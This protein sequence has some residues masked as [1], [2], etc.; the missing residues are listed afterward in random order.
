MNSP[1]FRTK[2]R[3]F[4]YLKNKKLANRLKIDNESLHYISI[5]EHADKITYI[6]KK[7]INMMNLNENNITITDATAGVGGNTLSFG[8]NFKKVNAVELDNLRYNYLNNNI[9][10]YKLANI[11]TFN[12]DSNVILRSLNHDIVFIDPPWGGRGYKDYDK[13]KLK[14]GD[15]SIEEVCNI[16]LDDTTIKENPKFI[17]LKLPVNYDY[18]YFYNNVSSKNIYFYDMN[19]MILLIIHRFNIK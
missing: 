18:I 7:H 13:L 14:L 16:L 1:S 19:K 6:I 11:D 3:I 10:V 9:S 12:A 17:V 8:I 5:R 15:I 4:P 2:L